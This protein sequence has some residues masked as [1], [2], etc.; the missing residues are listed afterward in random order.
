MLFSFNQ[1]LIS[2]ISLAP[3]SLI[4]DEL[5]ALIKEQSNDDNSEPLINESVIDTIIDNTLLRTDSMTI[6]ELADRKQPTNRTVVMN[7]GV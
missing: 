1:T 7:I 6:G 4:N 2:D 3:E 5:D